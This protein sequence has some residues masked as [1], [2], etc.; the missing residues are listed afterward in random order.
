V[1]R[2]LFPKKRKKL[3][4][5]RID[6]GPTSSERGVA[7]RRQPQPDG[8]RCSRSI[9]ATG[10]HRGRRHHVH[11]SADI[12]TARR[13]GARRVGRC[14]ASVQP[15]TKNYLPASMINQS[16][17]VGWLGHR[18]RRPL[19]HRRVFGPRDGRLT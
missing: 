6:E 18:P 13:V 11:L 1:V 3:V 7:G 14:P 5:I 4:E 12:E 17:W 10:L 9:R 16:P 15:A 8:A 19:T 2:L